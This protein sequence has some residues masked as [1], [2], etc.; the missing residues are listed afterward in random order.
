MGLRPIEA[1]T[2]IDDTA[3]DARLSDGQLML[4]AA[5]QA[6]AFGELYDRYYTRILN[7]AFRCTLSATAAEDLTSSTF[8]KALR[9]RRQYRPTAPFSSWLYQIA[10]NEIRMY[11][12]A[13]RRQPERPFPPDL[14]ERIHFEHDALSSAADL[15]EKL[16]EFARLHAAMLNLPPKYRLAIALRYFESLSTNEISRVLVKKPGTVTSLISRGLGMLRARLAGKG[17]QP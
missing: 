7:Y 9:S 6:W 11:W 13:R 10:T 1:T 4:I 17:E 12:R 15:E 3:T 16:T 5:D 2:R 8:M 14:L